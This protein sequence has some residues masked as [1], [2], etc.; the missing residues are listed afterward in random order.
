MRRTDVRPI[1]RR[2]AIADLLVPAR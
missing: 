1:S 2:R